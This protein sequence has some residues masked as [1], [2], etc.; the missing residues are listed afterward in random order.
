MKRSESDRNRYKEKK[1]GNNDRGIEVES[2]SGILRD[3]VVKK[4][5]DI[6]EEVSGI[7]GQSIIKK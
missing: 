3:K 2:K 6:E 4:Q 7:W 5:M 1:S